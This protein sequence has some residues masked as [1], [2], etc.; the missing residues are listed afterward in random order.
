MSPRKPPTVKGYKSAAFFDVDGTLVNGFL[1]IEFARYL[2]ERNLFPLNMVR[3]LDEEDNRFRSPRLPT[4]LEQELEDFENFAGLLLKIYGEGIRGRSKYQ[5]FEEA[6]KFIG[7]KSNDRF[8][9][10]K[11]LIRLVR[12]Y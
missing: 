1:L 3:K 10:T 11:P 8:I 6:G 7:S 2:N 5:I 9:Y 12:E 4:S